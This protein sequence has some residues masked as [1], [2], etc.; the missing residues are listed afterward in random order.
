MI[1]DESDVKKMLIMYD[2]GHNITEIANEIRV[3]R[4]TVQ[5]HLRK[6]GRKLGKKY[7]Y[8]GRDICHH[9]GQKYWVKSEQ[10]KILVEK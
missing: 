4:G 5:Y 1:V 8:C 7:M 3:V 2:S 9:C 6:N 10:I